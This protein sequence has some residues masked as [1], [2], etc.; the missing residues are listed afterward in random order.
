MKE[1]KFPEPG[2]FIYLKTN[3]NNSDST[4]IKALVVYIDDDFFAINCKTGTVI[5]NKNQTIAGR[6]VA[7][8]LENLAINYHIYLSD[9]GDN[10]L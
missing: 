3:I 1:L 5:S 10:E 7:E 6:S 2:D 4:Y 9:E 8:L